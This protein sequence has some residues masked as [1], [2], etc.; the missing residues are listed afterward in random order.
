MEREGLVLLKSVLCVIPMS[1]LSVFK[2]YVGVGKRL[3]GL[4]R[5]FLLKFGSCHNVTFQR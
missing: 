5:R 3:E 2:L 4:M 1:Y